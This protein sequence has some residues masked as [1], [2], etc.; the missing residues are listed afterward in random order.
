MKTRK[1]V[2]NDHLCAAGYHY[3]I[4]DYLKEHPHERV[5]IVYIY[6]DEGWHWHWY[7]VHLEAVY[8]MED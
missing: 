2:I 1:Q 4:L 7:R 8:Y 3:A 6:G 5:K